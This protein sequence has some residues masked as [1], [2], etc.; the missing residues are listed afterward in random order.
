MSISVE[1]DKEKHQFYAMV[2]GQRAHLDYTPSSDGKTLDYAHTFTPPAL[3]GRGIAGQITKVALEYAMTHHYKVI[4]TCP[5]VRSYIEAHPEYRD[6][7][8]N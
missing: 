3:R 5:F 7:I 1:H 6:L 2:E 4:P 8:T